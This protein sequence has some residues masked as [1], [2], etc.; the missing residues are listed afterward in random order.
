MASFEGP[1]ALRRHR[2]VGRRQQSG[3]RPA[4]P[5][6]VIA[7][8][9][10]AALVVLPA[11]GGAQHAAGRAGLRILAQPAA[12]SVYVNDRFVGTARILAER[13]APLAVGTHYVSILA[14][15]YFP[16]DLELDLPRGITTVEVTL[17]PIPP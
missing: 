14:P 12:A 15:G 16:H 17:R 6:L 4:G 7:L 1:S 5:W 9:G 10:L 11:C 2:A 8:A 13:P 3:G